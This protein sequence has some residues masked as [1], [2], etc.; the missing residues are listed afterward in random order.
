MQTAGG[1]FRLTVE[2]VVGDDEVDRVLLAEV[3]QPARERVPAGLPEHIADE[4]DVHGASVPDGRGSGAGACRAGRLWRRLSL[5][6]SAL[7]RFAA[8]RQ[9]LH[10]T[11]TLSQAR[12]TAR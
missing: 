6:F 10:R 7:G 4:E 2:L 5:H 12:S 1:S 3:G 9:R 11:S 8:A